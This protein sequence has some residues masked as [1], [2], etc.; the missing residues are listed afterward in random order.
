MFYRCARR[1]MVLHRR[2]KRDYGLLADVDVSDRDAPAT[3]T[4]SLRIRE[5]PLGP[6]GSGTLRTRNHAGPDF[7]L[8]SNCLAHNDVRT[9]PPASAT[10]Y[11][12]ATTDV[13]REVE[14]AAILPSASKLGLNRPATWPPAIRARSLG[15]PRLI[16]G[17]NCRTSMQSR[18]PR[19]NDRASP[20]LLPR[21]QRRPSRQLVIQVVYP[22]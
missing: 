4:A 18:R 12:R 7:F 5:C 22:L 1:D 2:T 3:I 11:L 9:V 16:A 14:K 15:R 20:I 13:D 21:S 8:D 10:P 6:L 19:S 17:P